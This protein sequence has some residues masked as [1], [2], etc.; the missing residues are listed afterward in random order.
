MPITSVRLSGHQICDYIWVLN[1]ALNSDET[2]LVADNHNEPQWTVDTALLNSFNE[3]LL[4]GTLSSGVSAPT[5]WKVYR[6]E[7]GSENFVPA[8]NLADGAT[9]FIDYNVRNK[10]EYVY[11]LFA[12]TTSYITAP[13]ESD[14]V[15]TNWATWS[16]FDVVETDVRNAYKVDSIFTFAYDTNGGQIS[17][18][19]Q[20]GVYPNFTRYAKVH[21]AKTNYFSGTLQSL[22]GYTTTVTDEYVDDADF[23]VLLNNF[24]T[25]G[26]KKFL[27][28]PKGL[29]WEVAITSFN[30][31]RRE[32]LVQMPTDIQIGWMVVGSADGLILTN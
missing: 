12:E 20:A 7:V 19:M 2:S 23:E 4:A 28:D 6:Q 16:L 9:S 26:R 13:L 24:T 3:S 17:N 8:A 22:L 15:V 1:R 18:N 32:K 14:A 29:I 31:A 27:K 25:N 10:K 30:I 5:A 21:Q 11:R